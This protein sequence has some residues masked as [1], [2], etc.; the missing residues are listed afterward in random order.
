MKMTA[1]TALERAEAQ[2]WAN[3]VQQRDNKLAEIEAVVS[4]YIDGLINDRDAMVKL[5]YLV[6][7]TD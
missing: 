3:L 4:W 6:K 7:R 1:K 2:E 5:V